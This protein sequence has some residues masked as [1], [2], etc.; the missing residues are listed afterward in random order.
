MRS[1]EARP[2]RTK[3]EV[4]AC[5]RPRSSPSASRARRERSLPPQERRVRRVNAYL[6]TP[7]NPDRQMGQRHRN[8]RRRS[9]CPD[10]GDPAHRQRGRRSRLNGSNDFI[11]DCEAASAETRETN[12]LARAVRRCMTRE[13][14]GIMRI[15]KP[16]VNKYQGGVL[17]IS[18][19][20]PST[21]SAQPLLSATLRC[22]AASLASVIQLEHPA[23]SRP[24]PA[25]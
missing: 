21:N 3:R 13:L 7:L 24:L 11:G 25:Q 22:C 14:V 6:R 12:K 16:T 19:K 4:Q 20:R 8:A 5:I 2:A 23:I 15:T 18:P 17:F 9:H 1:R 10:D